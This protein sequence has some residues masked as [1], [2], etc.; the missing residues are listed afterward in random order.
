M[1]ASMSTKAANTRKVSSGPGVG[2]KNMAAALSSQPF[3]YALCLRQFACGAQAVAPLT[4]GCS[5]L[6]G[7]DALRVIH[8]I[9]ND[10]LFTW[11]GQPME[12]CQIGAL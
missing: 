8:V 11:Q 10:A 1:S 2:T 3:F 7:I 5:Y 12:K 6:A 9:C 4:K